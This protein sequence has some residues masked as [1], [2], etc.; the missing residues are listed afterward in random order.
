MA[1]DGEETEARRRLSRG[2]CS[3]V[4]ACLLTTQ[5]SH[6]VPALRILHATFRKRHRSQGLFL[7]DRG[8]R[9]KAPWAC[10]SIAVQFATTWSRRKWEGK[11]CYW[12]KGDRGEPGSRV[13]FVRSREGERG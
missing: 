9:A 7:R 6:G 2:A 3:N 1:F 11:D 10:I 5:K 12:A 4:H 13:W 8:G